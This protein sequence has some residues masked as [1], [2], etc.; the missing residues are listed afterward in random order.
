MQKRITGGI[1][2]ALQDTRRQA[3]LG[4]RLLTTRLANACLD[5]FRAGSESGSKTLGGLSMEW[6]RERDGYGFTLCAQRSLT[7]AQAK[8]VRKGLRDA[9]L[10]ATLVES[11][12]F[13]AFVNDYSAVAA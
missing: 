11:H 12:R 9:C 6:C 10:N 4:L 3:H 13:R 5:S 8:A 2:I 1:Q 7:H